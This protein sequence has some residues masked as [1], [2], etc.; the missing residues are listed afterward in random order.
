[1]FSN[2][3]NFL[4]FSKQFETSNFAIYVWV[5]GLIGKHFDLF[6]ECFLAGFQKVKKGDPNRLWYVT[7]VGKHIFGKLSL[8]C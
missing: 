8:C 1:M 6:C 3:E 7:S 5:I 4:I 2:F